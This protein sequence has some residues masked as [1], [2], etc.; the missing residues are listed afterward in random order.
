MKRPF[1]ARRTFAAFNHTGDSPRGHRRTAI[2]QINRASAALAGRRP[3]MTEPAIRARNTEV[4]PPESVPIAARPA[5]KI[6]SIL[7]PALKL[8]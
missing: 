7:C 5:G 2:N 6:A 4:D 3:A 1:E 8:K